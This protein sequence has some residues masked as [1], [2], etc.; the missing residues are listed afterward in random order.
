MSTVRS[1]SRFGL[2]ALSGG[3]LITLLGVVLGPVHPIQAA[4]VDGGKGP[5]LLIG[6]DDDNTGNVGIQAGALADQRW[7]SFKMADNVRSPP[8]ST[9]LAGRPRFARFGWSH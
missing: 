1:I 5:Q 6:R 4:L 9:C 7:I 8:H 3:M 2:P